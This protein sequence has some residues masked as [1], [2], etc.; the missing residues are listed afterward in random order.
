MLGKGT[1]PGASQNEDSQLRA[2][3]SIDPWAA[4][5][6][7]GLRNAAIGLVARLCMAKQA[8]RTHSSAGMLTRW[9]AICLYLAR[10]CLALLSSAA[11]AFSLR[12]GT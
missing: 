4:L 11:C 6:L 3:I 10:L 9:F 2:L 7:R 12:K 5:Q 1:K 8:L